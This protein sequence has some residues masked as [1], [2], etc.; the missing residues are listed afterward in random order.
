MRNISQSFTEVRDRKITTS[1]SRETVAEPT[2]TR[3]SVEC[4]ETLSGAWRDIHEYVTEFMPASAE[5]HAV[6]LSAFLVPVDGLEVVVLF[7]G[8]HIL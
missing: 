1:I 2:D 7:E 5:A 3:L 4:G 8:E 6:V